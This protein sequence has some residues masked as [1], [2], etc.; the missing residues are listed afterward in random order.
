MLR[1]SIFTLLAVFLFFSFADADKF[2]VKFGKVSKDEMMTP[3]PAGYEDASAVVLFDIGYAIVDYNTGTNSFEVKFKRHAR[4]K[5]FNKEGYDNANVRIPIYTGKG[6]D[7]ENLFGV[8]AYSYNLVSGKIENEKLDKKNIFVEDANDYWSYHKFSIP[9]VKEGSIIEFEYQITSEHISFLREWEFQKDIPVIRSEYEIVYPEFFDYMEFQTGSEKLAG[10]NKSN[11]LRTLP[12]GFQYQAFKTQYLGL[13]IAPLKDEPYSGNIDNYRTKIEFQLATVRWPNRG[14]QKIMADW[15]NIAKDRME[16]TGYGVQINRS[17]FLKDISETIINNYS[18]PQEKIIAAHKYVTQ[19]IK[20][21]GIQSTYS[22][23]IRKALNENSGSSA[24][25]NLLLVALLRNVGVDAHP[26]ILSTR[27]H[28]KVHPIYPIMEKFNYVIAAA[29]IDGKFM[30][31]DAT[32]PSIPIGYLP[33]RVLNGRGRILSESH[34]QWI[35][36]NGNYAEEFAMAEMSLEDP[37]HPQVSLNCS[38]KGYA[39]F[40]DKV[41]INIDGEDSYLE[42]YSEKNWTINKYESEGETDIYG[43]LD[44]K[45][46]FQVDGVV[47]QTGDMLFIDPM[48]H[49]KMEDNLFVSDQRKH[50]VEFIYPVKET[51][52]LTIKIPEGYKVDELPEAVA[53][54]LPE[55]GGHFTYQVMQI[56]NMV[57]ITNMFSIDRTF[58]ETSY[59]PSLKHFFDLVAQKQDQKIVLKKSGS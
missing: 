4:I 10:V 15:P 11:L 37:D 22:S 51:F 20:W 6:R 21:N 24:D 34:N 7:V 26:V 42:K 28:G 45:I 8:K 41:A 23:N 36:I 55:D 38:K 16:S 25:I 17:G 14:S 47:Q 49:M 5:I 50:P 58:F 46:T 57:K 40:N 56:G 18:S 48:I 12:G 30:L 27:N 59:Y 1:K 29:I 32:A 13:N 33:K 54:A 35:N 31:V 53:L 19:N 39:A 3:K 43:S 9:K 2:K 52:I 44:E